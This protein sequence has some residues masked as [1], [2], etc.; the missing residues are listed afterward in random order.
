[1][2]SFFINEA[3]QVDAFLYSRIMSK[4]EWWWAKWK[5][6]EVK[7]NGLV[8]WIDVLSS[9]GISKQAT[10]QG[11]TKHQQKQGA[12]A[13]CI[14]R[15]K[16]GRTQLG[17]V[18][19]RWLPDEEVQLE[20]STRWLI[21]I[22][23]RSETQSTVHRMLTTD[24]NSD[25]RSQPQIQEEMGNAQAL[26]IVDIRFRKTTTIQAASDQLNGC[27]RG[28]LFSA[29]IRDSDHE[30]NNLSGLLLQSRRSIHHQCRERGVSRKDSGR[31]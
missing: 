7:K 28:K 21:E 12:G 14:N 5:R 1:M 27:L 31:N 19:R 17:F 2:N 9:R 30:A 11:R 15:G 26:R 24:C 25:S 4:V 20:D 23:L 6:N 10:E 3:V 22:P 8:K 13:Q 18:T 16:G 29:S